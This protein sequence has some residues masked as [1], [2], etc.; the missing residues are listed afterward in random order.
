MNL[1]IKRAN[2]QDADFVGLV[3]QLDAYLA[4]L[5]GKKMSFLCNLIPLK[6]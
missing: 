4:I 5:N 2:S 3:K 1:R 6:N